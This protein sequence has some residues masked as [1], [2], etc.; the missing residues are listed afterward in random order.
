M[1]VQERQKELTMRS[2]VLNPYLF[3]QGNCQE[4]MEFYKSIFGGDLTMQTYEGAPIDTPPGMEGKVM[5]A[6][7]SGGEVDIMASDTTNASPKAA[8][9]CLS[10]SGDDAEKLTTLFNRLSEDVEVEYPLKKEFWGDTFGSVTDKFG[11]EWMV[12]ISAKSE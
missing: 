5:H 9:V 10:L 2:I 12:N 1:L 4:A 11:I 7:L 8:K 6:G 3:F